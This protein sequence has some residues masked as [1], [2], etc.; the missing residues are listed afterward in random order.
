MESFRAKNLLRHELIGLKV[1]VISS[2]HIGYEGMRGKIIDETKNMLKIH[3]GIVEK[4][5]PK[6]AVTLSILLPDGY[7]KTIRGRDLIRRPIER[8]KSRGR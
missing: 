2:P 7:S 4:Q 8:V 6:E 3:N 1:E 5:V